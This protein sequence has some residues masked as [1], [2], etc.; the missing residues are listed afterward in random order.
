MA[1]TV[2][3][4]A[5]AWFLLATLAATPAGAAGDGT[6][7]ALLSGI[8]D[9]YVGPGAPGLFLEDAAAI[10]RVFT[11]STA[12]LLIADRA[13]ADSRGEM[14]RLDFDVFVGG[15]DWDL[16]AVPELRTE[17]QDAAHAAVTTA[18][19]NGG[20]A[21]PV[22]LRFELAKTAGGWR[23]DDIR[24]SNAPESLRAILQ[25]AE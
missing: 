16:A 6:P 1:P 13:E 20:A 12:E 15:Q 21:P 10:R 11:P 2:L 8:Y 22:T 18:P 9:H 25:R 4:P 19:A 17:V 23:I 7:D 3:R 24:W 14:G 5:T